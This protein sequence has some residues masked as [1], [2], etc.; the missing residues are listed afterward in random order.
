[1]VMRVCFISKY[2]PIEGGVSAKTYWLAK[3]LGE[4]GIEIFVITNSLDVEPEYKEVILKEDKQFF[5]PKNVKVF[6]TPKEAI[7]PIPRSKYYI[8]RLTN[9][10]IDVIR[11]FDI[12]LIYSHYLL[13][14]CVSA[15]FCKKLTNKPLVVRHAG[16]DLGKLY[17]DPYLRTL[18]VEVFRGADRIISSHKIKK[19]EKII[20]KHKISLDMFVDFHQY[21]NTNSFNQNVKPFDLSPYFNKSLENIPI[22]SYFGKVSRLKKT[23]EFVKAASLIKNR[24]FL[25]LFVVGKSRGVKELKDYIKSVGLDKKSV[26]IPFQPPWKIPSLMTLSSCVVCPESLEANYLPLGTHFPQIIRE[27]M[28]CGRC[29]IVGK[30]MASKPGYSH[31]MHNFNSIIV[32]STNPKEFAETMEKVID[33]PSVATQIGKR[34]RATA[35][36]VEKPRQTV[37]SLIKVFESLID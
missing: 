23:K 37:D 32:E 1:M 16:S 24:D 27:A 21:V 19:M 9:L 6:S 28:A 34:A 33:N 7:T 10:G 4:Q 5:E 22:F 18:F 12:D 3:A 8:A 31:L 29:T 15:L 35:I 20:K 11:K 30:G 13:P 36:K 2:P 26:F 25:M 14:Y 17:E